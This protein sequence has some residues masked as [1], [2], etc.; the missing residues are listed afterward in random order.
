M[1]DVSIRPTRASVCCTWGAVQVNLKDQL[2]GIDAN[3]DDLQA[4]VEACGRAAESLHAD[5]AEFGLDFK[6]T[7]NRTAV[8]SL[9]RQVDQLQGWLREQQGVLKE[10]REGIAR[11]RQEMMGTERSEASDHVVR[12]SFRVRSR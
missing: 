9:V 6:R 8:K 1:Q 7:T 5:A 12:R 10:L 11:S 2:A 4:G 3:L